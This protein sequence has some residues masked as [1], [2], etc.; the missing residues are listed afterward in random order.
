MSIKSALFAAITTVV[1]TLVLGNQWVVERAADGEYASQTRLS[2]TNQ[3][4][5]QFWDLPSDIRGA[6]VVRLVMLVVLAAVF[7]GIVGRSRPL[8]AF[9]GGWSAFLAA[10][11][12]SAGIYAVV[13]GERFSGGPGSDLVDRFTATAAAGTSLGMWFGWLVGIAV[14]L[15]SLGKG[16]PQVD[17][18]RGAPVPPSTAWSPPPGSAESQYPPPSYDPPPAYDPGGSYGAPAPAPAPPP[19]DPGGPQIGAPPDRT[20]VFG[21]PPHRDS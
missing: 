1:L 8:A 19:A 16:Q 13:V 6:T 21:Q 18:G 5:F 17:R 3:L 12:V 2:I 10:S 9:V 14:L 4:R 11:V 7:G 15:G 20:Q